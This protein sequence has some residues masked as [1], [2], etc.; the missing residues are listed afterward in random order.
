MQLT[1]YQN[2]YNT[3]RFERSEDGVLEVIMHTDGGE[4]LWSVTLEGHHNELGLAFADIAR[5]PE[6][7]VV[8]FTGS[9]P[10][11]IATRKPG[12]K[13]ADASLAHMW[14]R[15]Q[16]ESIAMMDNFLAI[17][18]PV[19]SA[20]NGP[21]LIHSELPVMADIVLAAEHAVFADTTHAPQRVVPGDGT[22]LIWPLLLG[23]NRGRY[24]L[25]TGERLSAQ[26]AHRLG[27]VAEV[28]AADELLP[29]A[30]ELAHKLAQTPRRTLR[31]TKTLL[32]RQLRKHLRDD[33]DLGLA[34]QGL[35]ILQ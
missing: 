10:N 27:V 6:N 31:H 5:D 9:G 3:I 11:F 15:M 18:V 34:V 19:I 20:V 25:L 8:I 16:I 12:E 32:V 2:R 21:C 24:F 1:D 35:G 29:R 28:L 7:Q 26:E 13:T 4:A 22:Q 14:E 33:M 30:R 17:P 23:P